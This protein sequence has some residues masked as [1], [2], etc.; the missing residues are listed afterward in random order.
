MD[1]VFQNNTEFVLTKLDSLFQKAHPSLVGMSE[2]MVKYSSLSYLW[3][4]L[5]GFG[6]FIGF[7]SLIIWS[8]R[9]IHLAEKTSVEEFW[10]GVA[11]FAGFG[12][13]FMSMI[14]L[15]GCRSFFQALFSP[16]AFTVMEILEKL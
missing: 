12:S 14:V 16:K 1:S 13:F 6:L 11:I 3:T 8:I 10:T 7:F 5:L 15:I 4:Y 2:E 9:K